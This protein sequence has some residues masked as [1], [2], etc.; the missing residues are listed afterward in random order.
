ML[1]L[2][3][4]GLCSCMYTESGSDFVQK[5]G[6]GNIKWLVYPSRVEFPN[7]ERSEIC[8]SD[9][10]GENQRNE[11]C[12]MLLV[13]LWPHVTVCRAKLLPLPN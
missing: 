13:T 11:L 7:V 5:C 1:G 9:G 3:G 6:E 12:L 4:V 10:S 2:L 8:R